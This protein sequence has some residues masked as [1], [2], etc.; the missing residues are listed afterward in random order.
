ME[1]FT[2][3]IEGPKSGQARVVFAAFAAFAALAAVA[4]LPALPAAA[5][6]PAPFT[7]TVGTLRLAHRPSAFRLAQRWRRSLRPR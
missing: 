2:T 6:T 1:R 5:A 4:A 3:S 7:L